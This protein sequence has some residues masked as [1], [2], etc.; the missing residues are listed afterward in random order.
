M[1]LTVICREDGT[2]YEQDVLIY[3]V[4]ADPNDEE[5]VRKAVEEAREADLGEHVDMEILFAFAGNISTVAD[6]RE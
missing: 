3:D 5:A 1:K 2:G 6:W 4:K